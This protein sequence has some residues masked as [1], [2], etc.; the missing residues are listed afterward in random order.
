MKTK[1]RS[2]ERLIIEEF[3]VSELKEYLTSVIKYTDD[4]DLLV[5]IANKAQEGK[6]KFLDYLCI[7]K[8]ETLDGR[9]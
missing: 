7:F 9:E 5:N 2:Q 4:M 6:T 8:I 3:T 1:Y